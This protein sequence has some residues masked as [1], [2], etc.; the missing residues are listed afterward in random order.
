MTRRALADPYWSSRQKCAL[1]WARCR[2][3]VMHGTHQSIQSLKLS[4]TRP[5]NTLGI[6]LAAHASA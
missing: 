4:I 5:K 1:N 3:A 6:H 2:T